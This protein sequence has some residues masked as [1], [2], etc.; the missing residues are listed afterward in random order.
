MKE[1]LTITG[2]FIIKN[3][4]YLLI[5]FAIINIITLILYI[6]DKKK[7]IKN[8]WRIPEATLIAFPFLGGFVGGLVGMFKFRHK[9]KHIK[10]L[11]LVP[12]SAIIWCLFIIASI[13]CTF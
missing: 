5:Y 12:L 10:F 6:A 7:A 9:T 8:Q 2:D 4:L 1:I 11:L 3:S 13:I